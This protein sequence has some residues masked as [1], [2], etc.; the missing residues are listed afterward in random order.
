MIAETRKECRCVSSIFAAIEMGGRRN[1]LLLAFVVLFLTS[2]ACGQDFRVATF[3]ADVTIP[4]NHRCMGVLP[5]K[6][7]RIKDPLEAKGFVLL[8]NERPIVVVAVD[9][10]E[11]RNGA[12]DQ[13]R[14]ALA[15]AAGTDRERVLVTSLHQHDAPVTDAGAAKLLRDAGLA[16]EL[17]DESFHDEVVARVATALTKSLT[18]AVPV[19]H[20]GTGKARVENI[21]SSRRVVLDDGRVSF[22]RGSRSGGNE[23]HS[24]APDGQIDP[25]VYQKDG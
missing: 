2:N 14:D 9:W 21:A 18:A 16:G 25:F 15:T 19:S 5:T 6:S 10:C 4:L 23:F 8:S 17:Y 22:G 12:Y 1:V 3:S 13:W 24:K 7:R 20:I 11:I